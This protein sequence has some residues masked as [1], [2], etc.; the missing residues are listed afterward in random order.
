[1]LRFSGMPMP[2]R[3]LLQADNHLLR[4]V[5]HDELCH[6]DINDSIASDR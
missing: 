5:P 4:N 3:P 2:G 6:I 1:M